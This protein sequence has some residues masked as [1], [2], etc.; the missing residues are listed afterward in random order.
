MRFDKKLQ[1]RQEEHDRLFHWD[2]S[3]LSKQDQL[4]HKIFHLAKYQ[5]QYLVAQAENDDERKERLI[6][7][8]FIIMVSMANNLQHALPATWADRTEPGF[9]FDSIVITTARL[10]K[11]AEAM[12]HMEA[13]DF[14]Q[15]YIT[16]LS[17]LMSLWAQLPG[18]DA[19]TRRTY[20][21]RLIAVEKRYFMHEK[22]FAERPDLLEPI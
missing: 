22:V 9:G 10:C 14:R 2:I 7:D 4:K 20:L 11:I 21:N 17:T 13:I 18:I 19:L 8:A 12:D 3:C 5:G 16:A 15:E 1:W 6:V